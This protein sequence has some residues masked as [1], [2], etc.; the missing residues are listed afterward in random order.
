MNPKLRVHLYVDGCNARSGLTT[1][2]HDAVTCLRCLKRLR[3][4]L[5]RHEIIK[6][7][8]VERAMQ[9][10]RIALESSLQS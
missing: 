10:N 7:D 2:F 3:L 6:T 4:S 1:S 8:E 9:R 5:L